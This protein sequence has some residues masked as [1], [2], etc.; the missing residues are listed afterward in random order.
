[1]IS[2][3][4][5]LAETTKLLHNVLAFGH[6]LPVDTILFSPAESQHPQ[7]NLPR[8]YHNRPQCLR[9]YLKLDEIGEAEKPEHKPHSS[10]YLRSF[11]P[12]FFFF[13]KNRQPLLCCEC[14]TPSTFWTTW[15][16]LAER[17][18]LQA[19]TS[20]VIISYIQ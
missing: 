12:Y 18:S 19:A 13:R 20:F 3:S 4:Q 9:I 5:K 17:Y 8:G 7:Q 10:L 15:R 6:F 1:L 11:L 14:L 16:N 2:S